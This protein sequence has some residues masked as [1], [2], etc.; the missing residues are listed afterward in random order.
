MKLPHFPS[1]GAGIAA[2]VVVVLVIAG[3]MHWA[4]GS[5]TPSPGTVGQRQQGGFGGGQQTARMAERLGMTQEDLQKELDSG[6]TMLEISAE[7]GI[8]LPLGGGGRPSGS[9]V[10][11]RGSGSMTAGSGSRNSPDAVR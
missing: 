3:G 1:F 4:A 5:V 7:H 9:G 6:K 2:G 8:E 11:L 10:I